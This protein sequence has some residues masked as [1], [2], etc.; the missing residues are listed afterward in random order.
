MSNLDYIAE[1]IG[2]EV[3]GHAES[4]DITLRNN[5]RALIQRGLKVVNSA[6]EAKQEMFWDS[7]LKGSLARF[8]PEAEPVPAPT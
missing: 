4:K 8:L 6:Y 5:I 3:L 7:M 2:V 1:A